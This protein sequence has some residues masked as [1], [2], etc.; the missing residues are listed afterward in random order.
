MFVYL[1]TAPILAF[2]VCIAFANDDGFPA[3]AVRSWFAGLGAGI[4]L[5][6]VETLL[7]LGMDFDLGSPLLF[8]QL[9]VTET[10]VPTGIGVGLFYAFARRYRRADPVGQ[11]LGMAAFLSGSLTTRALYHAL[12]IAE[13][14]NLYWS[15]LLPTVMVATVFLVPPMIKTLRKSYG[16]GFVVSLGA[17][18]VLLV[19]FTVVPLLHYLHFDGLSVVAA[20]VAGIGGLAAWV[21][22]PIVHA[23]LNSRTS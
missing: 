23:R 5:V 2:P 20:G 22:R 6:L 21:L 19:G 4:L 10:T 14:A 8:L 15:F 7:R 9:A 18:L 16:W 17:L 3:D 12:Y 1:L 13:S 11:E